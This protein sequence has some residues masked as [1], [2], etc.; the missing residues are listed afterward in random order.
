VSALQ[1]REDGTVCFTFRAAFSVRFR[2]IAARF[3]F[4]A[5]RENHD[6]FS[7]DRLDRPPAKACKGMQNSE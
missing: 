6:H 7:D 2:P 3:I 1:R 4:G 5:I